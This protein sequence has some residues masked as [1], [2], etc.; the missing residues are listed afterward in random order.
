M[1]LENNS[2]TA[3]QSTT[4]VLESQVKKTAVQAVPSEKTSAQ[5]DL[6]KES[7]KKTDKDQV[8]IDSK[9]LSVNAVDTVKN[10][11]QLQNKSNELAQDIRSTN[12]NVGKV[13]DLVSQMQSSLSSITKNFPPFNIESKERQQILMSYISIRKELIKM[14]VPPPASPIYEHIS[15]KWEAVIGKNGMIAP[16]AVPALQTNSSDSEVALAEKNLNNTQ[17]K[18]VGI[19]AAVNE[20]RPAS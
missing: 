3:A 16:D 13:T 14:S 18:L 19:T 2:V 11:E 8:K 5:S 15:S 4:T 6:S 1:G 7:V 12:K 9:P 20:F 17:G 10:L